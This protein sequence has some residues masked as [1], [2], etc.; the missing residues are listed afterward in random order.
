LPKRLV[1]SNTLQIFVGCIC[2]FQFLEKIVN[3]LAFFD[4]YIFFGICG[5]YLTWNLKVCL[6][7]C[8]STMI[9]GPNDKDLT[10]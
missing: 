5:S 3:S 6:R 1:S 10:K 2:D 4:L 8:R 9:A 7:L